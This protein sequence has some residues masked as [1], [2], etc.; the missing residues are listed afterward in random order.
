MLGPLALPVPRKDLVFLPVLFQAADAG[1]ET[2]AG[3][4]CRVLD[5]TLMPQLAKSLHAE[6]WTARLWVGTAYAIV[7]A[8]VTGPGWS[9]TV[10]V[11][12]LGYPAALPDSTFQPQGTD[13]LRL[14]GGQFMELMGKVGRE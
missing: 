7:Q 11:D 6:G 5:V 1:S 8:A 4:P 2:V 3:Q 9:G 10:A 12:K 14:T 13:V